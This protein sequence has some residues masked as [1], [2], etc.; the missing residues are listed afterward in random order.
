MNPRQYK[1]QECIGNFENF[2]S[3][4]NFKKNERSKRSTY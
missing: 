1:N 3:N 2:N 4:R